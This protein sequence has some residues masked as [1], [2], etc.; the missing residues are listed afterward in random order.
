MSNIIRFKCFVKSQNN[1]DYGAFE[2]SLKF[3][4]KTTWEK[5]K[6][7]IKKFWDDCK[8]VLTEVNEGI[9]L[10]SEIAGNINGI[11]DT[12][13]KII[14]KPSNSLSTYLNYKMPLMFLNGLLLLVDL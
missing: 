5:I 2:I 1:E 7:G 11:K 6:E 3:I 10:A 13:I 4:E 14:P 12:I 9:K 8:A